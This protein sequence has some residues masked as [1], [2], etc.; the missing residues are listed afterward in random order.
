M[1]DKLKTWISDHEDLIN[2]EDPSKLISKLY[3]SDSLGWLDFI[4][5]CKMFVIAGIINKD[6]LMDAFCTE[7]SKVTWSYKH[8]SYSTA[9]ARLGWCVDCV[10]LF[11]TLK[12]DD[13]VTYLLKNHDKYGI[14]MKPID[15]QYW[16]Q[17]DHPDYDLGWFDPVKFNKW[18]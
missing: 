9:E 7:L 17:P 1:N 2:S 6:A 10:G 12:Y 14:E 11:P 18:S 15:P 4:E 3:N 8:D 16:W 5:A 13:V